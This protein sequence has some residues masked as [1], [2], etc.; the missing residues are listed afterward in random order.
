[1]ADNPSHLHQLSYG[2]RHE[3]V[4]SDREGPF[5]REKVRHEHE[6]EPNRAAQGVCHREWFSNLR[7]RV[8][9]GRDGDHGGEDDHL[10]DMLSCWVEND[11]VKNF[12]EMELCPQKS[13]HRRCTGRVR[14]DGVGKGARASCGSCG[15]PCKFSI[16]NIS[17]GTCASA[18]IPVRQP[19]GKKD[20]PTWLHSR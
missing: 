5:C 19:S 4:S 6:V 13:P 7:R 18:I 8:D 11:D 1:M 14:Q 15:A 20:R 16:F 17:L 10:I 9:L 2:L 3:R 12:E